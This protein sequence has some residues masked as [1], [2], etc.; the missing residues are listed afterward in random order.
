[1]AEPDTHDG[2]HRTVASLPEIGF[3]PARYASSRHESDQAMTT[4]V[5]EINGRGIAAFNAE[6]RDFAEAFFGDKGFQSDMMTL[7]DDE[8]NRLWNGVDELFLREAFPR[9]MLGLP[10]LRP[11]QS[12]TMRLK[13]RTIHGCYSNADALAMFQ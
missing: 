11:E 5:V 8:G 9:N 12:T 3:D 13:T 2:E 1:V 7:D 4:Y 6:N 10:R